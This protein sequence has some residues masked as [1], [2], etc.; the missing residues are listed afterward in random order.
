MFYSCS[1]YIKNNLVQHRR[2][3]IWAQQFEQ[4][5]SCKQSL[6]FLE[7]GNKIK[8]FDIDFLQQYPL[9]THPRTSEWNKKKNITIVVL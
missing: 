3:S 9:S 6:Y 4:L 7:E 8:T 2:I 1:E 5:L